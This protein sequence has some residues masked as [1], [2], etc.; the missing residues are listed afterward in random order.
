MSE[1]IV[2]VMPDGST[3]VEANGVVGQSCEALT[4]PIEKA[5]GMDPQRNRKPEYYQ[6]ANQS[7]PQQRSA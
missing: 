5:L 3:R 1:V 7:N 2:T 4:A 6:Q